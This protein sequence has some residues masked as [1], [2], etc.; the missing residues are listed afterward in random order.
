MVRGDALYGVAYRFRD[1]AE[2]FVVPKAGG[3]PRTLFVTVEPGPIA[4]DDTHLYYAPSSSSAFLSP[5]ASP[6]PFTRG[7]LR[8]GPTR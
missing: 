1:A 4:V 5:E 8:M 2:V 7:S 6:R 3:T